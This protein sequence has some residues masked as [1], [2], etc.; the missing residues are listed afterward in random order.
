MLNRSDGSR[1]R[2]RRIRRF[3]TGGRPLVRN[4]RLARHPLP[5]K[6]QL[7]SRRYTIL[8]HTRFA[9]RETASFACSSRAGRSMSSVSALKSRPK[10]PCL[11][12]GSIWLFV[13]CFGLRPIS[14]A[15]MGSAM[16]PLDSLSKDEIVATVEPLKTQGKVNENTRFPLIDLKEPTKD[17]VASYS[18]R[19]SLAK[20]KSRCE[21]N[22]IRRGYVMLL[23]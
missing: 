19:L 13:C 3:G 7:L 20:I 9:I 1:H 8:G 15:Q 5:T 17:D 2:K 23:G 18:Y 12:W 6:Y 16:H 11:R 14:S 22:N 21:I 10:F 4:L